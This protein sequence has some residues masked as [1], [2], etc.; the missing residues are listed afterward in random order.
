MEA[1]GTGNDRIHRATTSERTRDVPQQPR[2]TLVPAGRP[3]HRLRT[4]S[5][6]LLNSGIPENPF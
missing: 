1:G 5:L 4:G 3:Y 6:T 2:T